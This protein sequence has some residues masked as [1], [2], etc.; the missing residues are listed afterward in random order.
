MIFYSW[1]RKV[2]IQVAQL[3]L[4]AFEHLGVPVAPNK[5]EGPATS[6]TFLGIVIDAEYF[7]LRL[8][9]DKL[10]QLQ[11]IFATWLGQKLCRRKELELLLGHLL[12]SSSRVAHFSEAY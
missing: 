2:L 1:A 12:P 4:D 7:Q 8:P 3:W 10:V 9:I 6:I 11:D 5:I